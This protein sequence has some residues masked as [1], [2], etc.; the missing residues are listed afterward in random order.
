MLKT[1]LAVLGILAVL[2]VVAIVGGG[3][4]A[5][6]KGG[7]AMVE[8]TQKAVATYVST[9]H[10]PNQVA[11]SL[12]RI[13]NGAKLHPSTTNTFMI[14]PIA[15]Q[16]TQVKTITDEQVQMLQDAAQLSEQNE[17]SKDQM[18]DFMRKYQ[19]SIPRGNYPQA[20]QSGTP[21]LATH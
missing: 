21:Q 6:K 12:N 3:Y 2:A 16:M 17:I 11:D 13:V 9:Q 5:Y 4:F 18:H 19:N 8:M 7:S 10:P 15:L 14:L 1:I 20:Q